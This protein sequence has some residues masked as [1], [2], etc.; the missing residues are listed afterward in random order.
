M[1][2]T[3]VGFTEKRCPLQELKNILATPEYANRTL[4]VKELQIL[5]GRVGGIAKIVRNG[6]TGE[7][8]IVCGIDHKVLFETSGLG[9]TTVEPGFIV[10]SG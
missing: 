7:C 2:R 5:S 4:S 3:T 10:Y 9:R 1:C 6:E 8:A